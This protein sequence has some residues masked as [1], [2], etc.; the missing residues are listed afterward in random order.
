MRLFPKGTG[1]EKSKLQTNL[2]KKKTEMQII[3]VDENV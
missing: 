2:L 3:S 1:T